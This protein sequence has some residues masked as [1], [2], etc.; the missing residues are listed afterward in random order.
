MNVLFVLCLL[1]L[2][3]YIL[4]LTNQKVRIP[5]VIFLIAT[6][7]GLKELVLRFYPEFY[8][9]FDV[10]VLLPSVGTIGLILIVL[11]GSIELELTREKLNIVWKSALIAFLSILLTILFLSF[12]V[13]T[14]FKLETNLRV[15]FLNIT[16][17]S[18]ISSAIAIPS[19]RLM[20]KHIKEFVIYESSLSDIIGVIVF[21][22]FLVNTSIRFSNVFY[23]I[24]ET[25]IMLLISIGVSIGLSLF[26]SKIHHRI[27]FMPIII[28]IM[29]VYLLSKMYHLPSLLLILVFGLTLKNFEKLLHFEV[30]KKWA[31]YFQPDSLNRE[32]KKFEDIVNEGVFLIKTIFFFLFG[33]SLNLEDILNLQNLE[34]SGLIIL[35]IYVVRS[36]LLWIFH[37]NLN[38]IV[39]FAPRGL[40]SILLFLSIPQNVKME[41]ISNSVLVQ[42]VLITTFLMMVGN[43]LHK[44]TPS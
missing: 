32:L 35:I 36:I 16:P 41:R 17:L 13:I 10:N 44:K 34:V 12:L 19:V 5:S 4:E 25:F 15:V 9:V 11:E 30:S 8:Q 3:S 40:I 14:L 24:Y 2:F 23:F 31:E 39:F 38:P 7:L 21:N 26:L 22:F 27:K 33:Y 1:L 18:I 6:G 37:L 42:V 28:V 43:F 20:S 29:L